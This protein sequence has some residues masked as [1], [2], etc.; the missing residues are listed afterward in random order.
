MVYLNSM[1]DQSVN[2]KVYASMNSFINTLISNIFFTKLQNFLCDNI[3]GSH[4]FFILKLSLEKN[5]T[6]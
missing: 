1:R 4:V 5:M 2:N 6:T 3:I